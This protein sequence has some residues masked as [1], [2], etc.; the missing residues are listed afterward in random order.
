LWE[1]FVLKQKLYSLQEE[2]AKVFINTNFFNNNL[3][4]KDYSKTKY[5][6]LEN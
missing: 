5:K 6:I 2:K 3:S 1:N 4:L